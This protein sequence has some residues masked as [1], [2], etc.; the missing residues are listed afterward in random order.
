M[1]KKYNIYKPQNKT[2][3]IN[4]YTG[5]KIVKKC[6]DFRK[7]ISAEGG[8]RRMTLKNVFS[9]IHFDSIISKY[10]VVNLGK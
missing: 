2:R 3:L 8:G 9:G 1:Q 5:S 10:V 4:V 7:I 6:M